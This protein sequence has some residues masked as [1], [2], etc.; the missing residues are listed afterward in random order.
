LGR[1]DDVEGLRCEK[2]GTIRVMILAVRN[3]RIVVERTRA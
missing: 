2:G 1:T 3:P